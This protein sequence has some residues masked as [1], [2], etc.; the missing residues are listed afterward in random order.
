LKQAVIEEAVLDVNWS[1]NS[2][3]PKLFVV[4]QI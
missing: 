4:V 3:Q 1:N 2:T